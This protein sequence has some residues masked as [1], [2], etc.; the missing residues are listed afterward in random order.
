MHIVGT[1]FHAKHHIFLPGDSSAARMPFPVATMCWAI[2]ASSFFC[3]VERAGNWCV[4][5]GKEQKTN[6]LQNRP[7]SVIYRTLIVHITGLFT[8]ICKYLPWLLNFSP[9]KHWLL[10]LNKQVQGSVICETWGFC[11]F[12]CKYVQNVSHICVI[13]LRTVQ[14]CLLYTLYLWKKISQ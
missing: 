8:A 11:S 10:A 5:L 6:Y 4:M 12:P 9:E 13:S 14:K 3:S 7:K 1:L 2:V